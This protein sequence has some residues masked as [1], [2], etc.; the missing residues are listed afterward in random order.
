MKIALHILVLLFC[1]NSAYN[2]P[3]CI[4]KVTR[5][6]APFFSDELYETEESTQSSSEQ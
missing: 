6:S 5:D 1:I 3:T 2:C 4:G